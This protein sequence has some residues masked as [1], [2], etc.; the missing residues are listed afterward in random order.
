MKSLFLSGLLFSS[1]A[2]GQNCLVTVEA[3]AFH[4]Q[5]LSDK[6]MWHVT[7]A[8][9]P[10]RDGDGDPNH[11]AGS[12]G[13]A[14]VEVLPDT[15]RSH[16]DKLIKGDN[17][18]DEPG[19][20][21]VL[22]YKILVEQP[23][24]YYVWVRIFS[25]G[26]EDNGLHFGLNGAWPKSG[27]RWQTTRKGAWHWDCRQRTEKVHV[28]VPMQLWLD[29]DKAGEH[30]LLMAMREDGTEVDQII[31]AQSLDFRPPGV[32]EMKVPAENAPHSLKAVQPAAPPVKPRQPNGKVMLELP[33]LWDWLET[34]TY[35]SNGGVRSTEPSDAV[36]ELVDI[37]SVERVFI[38]QGRSPVCMAGGQNT[39]AGCAGFYL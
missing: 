38:P 5:V 17:F 8:E 34:L 6:R 23:G 14:Y 15:R 9:T 1:W 31:L 29:I 10:A 39:K 16:D 12:S 33:V 13:G 24:R 2:A 27:Q 36:A 19:T 11:A 7:K 21:A 25:A 18:T 22:S 4:K 26:T 3:E 32:G 20:M 37:C 30:E 28:G 35:L